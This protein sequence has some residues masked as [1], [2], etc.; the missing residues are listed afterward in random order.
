[1]HTF[2]ED[3]YKNWGINTEGGSEGRVRKFSHTH[4]HTHTH[5]H[6]HTNTH[7]QEIYGP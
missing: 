4:T 2:Y 5:I 6:T 7:T 3:V 1:L